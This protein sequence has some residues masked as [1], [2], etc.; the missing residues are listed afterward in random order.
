METKSSFIDPSLLLSA[1]SMTSLSD[2]VGQERCRWLLDIGKIVDQNNVAE[3]AVVQSGIDFLLN[4]KIRDEILFSKGL[5]QKEVDQFCDLKLGD[6]SKT[7][8]LFNLLNL[9]PSHIPIKVAKLPAAEI[10]STDKCLYPYQ[11]WIRKKINTFL[12]DPDKKKAIVHMPTGAG[13]TRTSMESIVDFVRGLE[14][15]KITV[16]WLAHSE[17]LCEQ[18]YEQISAL[19]KVHSS[20]P[21]NIVRLWGGNSFFGIEENK[22]NFIISSFQ[23][24]HGMLA[25]KRSDVFSK[26]ADIK[27]SNSLLVVDEAHQSTADTY[28]AAITFLTNNKSKLLG[29]T[30][31]PGRDY[32][33]GDG[34][35]TEELARFYDYNKIDIVGDEGQKL[36]DE[37]QFLQDKKVLAKVERIELVTNTYLELSTIERR[38][39]ENYLEVPDSVLKTLG[40]DQSRTN[41]IIAQ[42]MILAV[43]KGLQTIV[44]AATQQNAIDMAVLLR[45]NNCPAAAITSNTKDRA[46]LITDFK[47]GKIKVLTNFG[48]LTT[49]FDAPNIGAVIIAR[50]TMSV[51]LYSQMIGRGLRGELMGGLADCVVVDVLDNLVNMPAAAQAF[52]YFN[53]FYSGDN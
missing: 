22:L 26:I 4:K 51:V 7:H 3:L 37:I 6:N 1:V 11:N 52:T 40:Q 5:N 21:A 20:E 45:L 17:E 13:K 27:R 9:C 31:T 2:F 50:P 53:D 16:V 42:I 10:V 33:G 36:D 49:G 18:A 39:I 15:S 34:D 28:G 23:T 8:K 44:F 38:A 24:T 47:S 30:A 12:R 25:S 32:L 41:L 35:A 46:N 14:E 48:V 29:L 19:W 43:E